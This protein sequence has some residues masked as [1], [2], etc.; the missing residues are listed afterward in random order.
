MISML[1]FVDVPVSVDVSVFL[2][3]MLHWHFCGVLVYVRRE[4]S[5]FGST[6]ALMYC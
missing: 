5:G 3:V 2:S 1:V 6:C 4:G